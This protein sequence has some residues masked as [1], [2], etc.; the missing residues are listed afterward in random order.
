[1]RLWAILAGLAGI[2][3][4]TATYAEQSIPTF[5]DATIKLDGVPD[6][7]VWQQAKQVDIKYITLPSDKGQ[8]SY[9]TT[10]R[11]FDDGTTL[12]IAFTAEEPDAGSVRAQYRN[13]DKLWNDD[14]IGVKIDPY[15]N[16]QLAYQFFVNPLGSVADS[17]E[18]ALTG[19]ESMGWDGFWDAAGQINANGYTVEIAIPFH[20]MNFPATAGEKTFAME[21]LR[22]RQRDQRVRVSSIPI[23]HA[24]KCWVCQLQPYQGFSQAHSSQ[25]LVVAPA[26]VAGHSQQRSSAPDSQWQKANDVALSL[27]L[28]WGISQDITLNATLNPDF[29]QV[30]ADAAQ[31][32]IN[33]PFTLFFD[34]SRPFFTENADYFAS[35]LDLVYTRNIAAPNAGAKLT[36]RLNQHTFGF[37]ATDDDST[38]LLLPGNLGSSVRQLQQKSQNAAGRYSIALSD[39]LTLGT[40]AT[41]RQSDDYQ[42]NVVGIDSHF[43]LSAQDTLSAQ[44]LYSATQDDEALI[45]R[46]TGEAAARYQD[47]MRRTDQA[48]RLHYEHTQTNWRVFGRYDYRGEN[49]RADL[50]FLPETD[51]QKQLFG[52]E[53]THFMASDRWL[54]RIRFYSDWD[55]THN[56]AGELLER[57]LEAFVNL[58]G[59]LESRL[60]L[61]RTERLRVG[62]R[63]D[64]SVLSITGNTDRFTEQ[65]W[66]IF[67]S[68]RPSAALFLN[69]RWVAGDV[70]DLTNNRL[71]DNQRFNATVTYA[72]NRHVEFNVRYNL[73]AMR[74]Q[75]ADVFTAHLTDFR[76]TY[77]FSNRSALRLALIYNQ[78]SRNLANYQPAFQS[79]LSAKQ[80]SLGSQ[81]L[82]SYR[83]NPQTVFFAGYSDN[84]IENDEINSLWPVQRNVF[85]KFSYAWLP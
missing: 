13:R 34:E 28:K 83:Y 26:L 72:L 49:F 77:Q 40:V 5:T 55:I 16:K 61:G 62:H 48:Y 45:A 29:S 21:F 12:Y 11:V 14:F 73:N 66:S 9:R 24:N 85:I 17:I 3:F 30:E 20:V 8:V 75:G 18:N 10:A 38:T 6:E 59:P 56:S 23:S 53:Y 4:C 67:G 65:E 52:G 43:R 22:Y 74:Y 69:S 50:G 78:L 60:E 68:V 51:W 46:L 82:Y 58:H 57:E 27:D 25:H 81:L 84:A 19:D 1:M 71:S 32:S 39:R 35:P 15:N 64:T 42:N 63:L 33:N 36:G 76:L 37:F 47:N 31:L 79:L 44:W 70:V 2:F 41:L 54:N 80:N 7:A